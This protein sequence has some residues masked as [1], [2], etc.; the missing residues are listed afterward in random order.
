MSS[1]GKTVITMFT[2]GESITF[3]AEKTLDDCIQTFGVVWQPGK[4]ES[5]KSVR[6]LKIL[7]L[8]GELSSLCKVKTVELD[9]KP[10]S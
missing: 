10:I 9:N 4:G 6:I 8:V 7:Q 5:E 2:N 1:E 3:N